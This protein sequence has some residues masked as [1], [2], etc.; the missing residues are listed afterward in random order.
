MC[1]RE[2]GGT[3]ALYFLRRVL[4]NR[5]CGKSKVQFDRSTLAELFR[6]N[7][8]VVQAG[9][10]E[11]AAPARIPPDDFP[12]RPPK[13]SLY[14]LDQTGRLYFEGYCKLFYGI[15]FNGGRLLPL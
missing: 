7:E 14:L 15:Y 5:L 3:E 4:S 13:N 11:F 1:K 12:D 2:S 9:V 8:P 6:S 10:V